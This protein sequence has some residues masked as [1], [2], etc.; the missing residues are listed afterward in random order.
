MA[1]IAE[2]RVLGVFAKQ[3][4]P[5]RVKTRLAA[6]T[7]PAWAAQV[8]SAFLHDAMTRLS[9]VEARRVLAFAPAHAEPYFA[10][11]VRGRF[12]L[13]P[14]IE[15]DLGRRMAHFF[16][17]QL[18]SGAH[19]VVLVGTDSPTLPVAMIESVFAALDHADVVLG[20]ATDGGYYLV[21]CSR[22]LPPIFDGIAW[23]SDRVLSETV[24]RLTDPEWRL[25]L[26]PPWYDVDTAQDWEMLR[27]HLAAMERAGHDPGLPET[28]RLVRRPPGA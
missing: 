27:G 23:S 6:S 28:M 24:D 17:T 5:G 15:A 2:K 1:A 8:A 3:P 22:R 10:E 13:I 21:G 25:A 18:D 9:A 19:Q 14:Q 12:E 26:L 7:S 16:S 4:V 20:P 11:R